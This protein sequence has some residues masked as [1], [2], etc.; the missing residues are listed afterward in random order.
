MSCWDYYNIHVSFLNR[1]SPEMNVK[2]GEKLG[3]VYCVKGTK[4]LSNVMDFADK[5]LKLDYELWVR[6]YEDFS[7]K[8]ANK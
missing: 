4:T 3:S 7:E 6:V 2:K 8:S 5:K 1:H